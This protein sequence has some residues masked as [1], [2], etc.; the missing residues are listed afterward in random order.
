MSR[1]L[2]YALTCAAASAVI[3]WSAGW[4]WGLPLAVLFGGGAAGLG[5]VWRLTPDGD[6]P[7]PGPGT[8]TRCAWCA[9]TSGSSYGDCGCTEP[10]PGIGWCR[11]R[12]RSVFS[13]GRQ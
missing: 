7:G 1:Y 6:G 13:G 10:C 3:G 11:A 9:D 5:I 2:P 8:V 4:P 12:A